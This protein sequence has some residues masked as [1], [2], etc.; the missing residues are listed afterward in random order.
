M[1]DSGR[2]NRTAW[3]DMAHALCQRIIQSNQGLGHPDT[4]AYVAAMLEQ[5]YRRGLLAASKQP[6]VGLKVT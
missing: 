1:S 6:G 3:D 2:E 5:S 4:E